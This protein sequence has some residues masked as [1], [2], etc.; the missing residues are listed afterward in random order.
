MD[1]LKI[2][3]PVVI[4]SVSAIVTALAGAVVVLF[5]VIMKA[6]NEQVASLSR[7]LLQSLNIAEVTANRKRA[8]EGKP[9]LEV[10]ADVVP[11]HT[12]P[13]T[14]KQVISADTE[15]IKARVAKVGLELEVP[16][17]TDIEK[18]MLVITG[19]KMEVTTL[20]AEVE[21]ATEK[22]EDV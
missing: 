4:G 6:H 22:K 18:K 17:L 8:A 13:P 11:E 19:D 10:L 3:D 21:K 15:T 7:M 12:S 2:G 14:T 1:D 20:S 16:P 9:P 5:K